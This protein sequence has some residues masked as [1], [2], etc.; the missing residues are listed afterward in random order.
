MSGAFT[1]LGSLLVGS[2]VT[3]FLLDT[4]TDTNGTNLQSHTGETGATWT[5]G[6]ATNNATIN[7][8]KLYENGSGVCLY[9]C[10]GVGSTA[11]YSV[12]TDIVFDSVITGQGLTIDARMSTNQQNGYRVRVTD[13]SL[14]LV[15]VVSNVETPIG[16][17]VVSES[18]A[19]AT[20]YRILFTLTGTSLTVKL[21][22]TQTHTATDA[23]Y[24]TAG[25]VGIIYFD[26]GTGGST[27]TGIRVD[28]MEG[29]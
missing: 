25:R 4:F 20:P 5:Q 13:S 15:I 22:G 8:N 23:V 1:A 12:Q 11:D 19:T 3:D 7:S 14:D 16:T 18:W 29:F 21:N 17:G 6:F 10:S 26:S 28:R 24:S 2:S 27:S 9:L